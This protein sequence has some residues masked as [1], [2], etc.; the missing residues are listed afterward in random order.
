MIATA[1]RLADVDG[2]HLAQRAYTVLLIIYWLLL[3][4]A[5]ASDDVERGSLLYIAYVAPVLLFVL[6]LSVPTLL[7]RRLNLP[8]LLLVL[9]FVP[10]ML[11]ALLRGDLSTMTSTTL[12]SLALLVITGERVSPPPGL[13]NMVFLASI[14]L[15]L[16]TYLG[17]SNIYGVVPGLGLDEALPWRISLFPLVPESAFFSA[18]VLCLNLQDRRLPMGRTCIV[19]AAYFLLFSG[20]RSAL[21]GTVLALGFHFAV[22]HGLVRRPKRQMLLFFAALLLF[23]GSMLMSQLLTLVPSIG[24]ESVNVYLFRTESGVETGDELART[25]YRTWLWSEHLRLA[26]ENPL[27][28][29]G[30]NSFVDLADAPAELVL[31]SGSESFLTGLYARVGVASLLLVA[32]FVALLARQLR[33]RHEVPALVAL[34]L[35]VAMLAYGSF[36]VP[37]NFVFLVMVGLLSSRPTWIRGA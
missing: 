4:A 23:T 35:F 30:T 31:G 21:I 34:L 37:Y 36:L 7:R 6:M 16:V 2:G 17:G 5:S 26:A 20:L 18:I 14:P 24:N 32:F 25:V 33:A 3:Y 11:V 28:G 22:S 27:L 12:M 10:V 1:A 8:L 19:L 29:I 13:L 9:Y 15:S